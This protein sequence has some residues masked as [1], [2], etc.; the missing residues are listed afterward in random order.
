[1]K[2][3]T[4]TFLFFIS[5]IIIQS[6]LAFFIIT[7]IIKKN[8]QEDAK[9]ELTE[10]ASFV[11]ESFNAWKRSLW[12]DLIRLRED[13]RL[14][15][16]LLDPDVNSPTKQLFSY[17]RETVLAGGIDCMVI[18]STVFPH[19]ELIPYEYS[20]FTL[21]D[22]Q[23]LRKIKDH[24]YLQT[25][26]IGTGLNL[27][28]TCS[29][30]LSPDFTVD[31]FLIKHIGQ[32]FCQNLTAERR[33]DASFVIGD[34]ILVGDLIDLSF[35]SQGEDFRMRSVYEELY[36]V[37]IEDGRYNIAFN[38]LGELK[39]SAGTRPLFLV[40][41][42]SNTP[43]QKRVIAVKRIVLFVSLL[44]ALLTAVLSLFLSRNISRPVKKLL[45]GMYRVKNGNYDT[46]IGMKYGSEMGEL[47]HGFNE[48]ALKLSQD[49]AQMED[50][51]REIIMLKDYS[52]KI[53]H[54]IRAGIAIINPSFRIEKA[55][56]SFL[57]YVQLDERQI[58]GAPIRDAPNGLVDED[59]LEQMRLLL[60]GEKEF[61]SKVKRS[62][63]HRVYEI[64]LYPLAG[65]RSQGESTAGCVFTV[66]DIS[67]K[68]ELEEKIFQAEKLSSLSMLSAGV[69]HEINNPLSSIM[70]NVQNLMEEEWDEER[71]VSLGWIEQETLR[72]A[73]TVRALLNFSSSDARGK[74][75]SDVNEVIVQVIGIIKY[76]I[77]RHKDIR[78]ETDLADDLPKAVINEDELQQVILNLVHNSI[79]AVEKTGVVSVRT[80]VRRPEHRI[81]IVVQDNGGGI[82]KEHIPHIFDPF[83]TTKRDGQGT[84]LGLSVV[85]GIVRKQG[86]HINIESEFGKGTTIALEFPPLSETDRILWNSS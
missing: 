41:A 55:N 38:K 53:I 19:V 26:L 77:P 27:V 56:S 11:Y 82:Q 64:K 35:F 33:S 16:M 40:T 75:G 71:K 72:I 28:G 24:P 66:D 23:S 15:S 48:M 57:R 67:E 81:R 6:S 70:S 20:I 21:S 5:I 54:S 63:D 86:G 42:L 12:I 2:L 51:I 9:K 10:E 13:G 37:K 46:A 22:L 76:S 79:Q 58:I 44:G 68:L 32:N 36:D 29:L 17:I 69:A 59:I 45:R 60:L 14:K 74:Q 47:L 43:Y 8:N 52:E 50:Y 78:I 39:T 80:S 73:R 34:Q 84:G 30:D 49:K 61:Y 7:N 18:K 62:E 65:I 83:F 31:M 1:M 85:Y 25:A 3:F 4:K